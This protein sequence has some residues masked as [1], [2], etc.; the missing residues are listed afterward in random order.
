MASGVSVKALRRCAYRTVA[1]REA[2]LHWYE[3][4]SIDKREFKIKRYTD[5]SS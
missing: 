5:I 4:A 3:A 2:E 1:I